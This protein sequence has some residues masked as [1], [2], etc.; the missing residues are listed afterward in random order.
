MLPCVRAFRFGWASAFLVLLCSGAALRAQA[1]EGD[2]AEIYAQAMASFQAGEFPKAAAEL[3]AL[4]A[5]AEFSPQLEPIFYTIGS[6]HFNAGDYKKASAAFRNYQAKFPTGPHAAEVTFALAQSALLSK[7]YA[8]AAKQFSAL[9]GNPRMREQALMAE[10]TAHKESGKVD[11]AITTLEKLVSGELT[12][13][14]GARGA[15]MLAQLYGQKGTADRAVATLTKLHQHVRLVDNIVELNAMT[16]ELGDQLFK[17]KQFDQA[18]ECYRAAYR[19]EQIIRLQN[20]RI[21]AMQQQIED[22]VAAAR[23]DPAQVAQ[24]GSLN[25]QLKNDIAQA[26]RLLGEFEKLPDITPA[27]YI[28]LARC[29]YETDKKWE[30]VVVYQ[31]LLD[32]FPEAPEREPSL[33]GIIVALAEVDQPE[34]SMK[35][36]EEYLRDFK[37]GPNAETVGYLLGAAALQANDAGAAEGYFAKM[38]ETQ[39][40]G[41]Y[42]EQMR[43]LL[44]NAKL[45]SGKFEEAAAE[46]K[47][48]L[49]EYPKGASV[50]DVVYRI[51]LTSL[52]AGQYEEAIKALGDYMKKYPEGASVSDAKYRLAV[53]KYAAA[54]YDEVIADGTAWEAEYGDHQQL[55]EVLA[56]RAD[57]YG[58]MDREAEAIPIYIRS[59]QKATTDEV[60]NYSLFAAS[61][62]LQ[63]RDDWARVSKLFTGFI[64]DKPDHPSVITALSWIGKAKAREGDIE[65]AKRITADTIKKYIGDPQREPVEMLLTQ[66]AQLCARK[67][68][69]EPGPAAPAGADDGTPAPALEA[70]PAAPTDP[71][72]ELDLLLGANEDEEEQNATTRARILFAKAELARLRRQPAE[73]EKNI[74]RLAETFEPAAL[75]PV[76]LGRAADYLL[77]RQKTEEARAF[78]QY[79]MDEFPNSDSIDYAYHGLGEIAFRKGEYPRALR[80]FSDATDKIIAAAKLK[81][82]TLGKA[83][84]LLAL[85]QL[86]EAR[87][88]FEQVA[89]VRE[90]RGEATAFSVYSLGEIEARRGR[91]AEANAHFQRVYVGYQKFL[92]WVAK[93]Y[94]RSAESFEKLGKTQEAANTYRE[95]LRNEKLA[96]FAEAEEA[97]RKLA[98]LGQG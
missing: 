94:L 20:D 3:E 68:R 44:A 19:R 24:L 98:A 22:N 84:T 66:L 2:L 17:K 5:R 88:V 52:F 74:A 16:V 92:P 4:V 27:I 34:R 11:Q 61:K 12:T 65:G 53:C 82:V 90:W 48:Y 42:R 41:A 30:A 10:A 70:T 75:S 15:M 80:L 76:L 56:L 14:A 28:R 18:L 79:L 62:L 95:M 23:A 25:N 85:D 59:Y 9:E 39:T 26:Q 91:W 86:E 64:E 49:T 67:K 97:R 60:M 37:N 7:D 54:L 81:D 13:P 83:K 1:S 29:F 32:R 46:Y 93:A 69:P 31:E 78:Y 58:A 87:K 35:R 38:L 96:T 50:E 55:G 47:K 21:A 8:A 45:M 77:A 51:A 6:A 71:G 89:A 73:E 43:Y 36:S 57:A 63:K 33:F 40:K 72:A